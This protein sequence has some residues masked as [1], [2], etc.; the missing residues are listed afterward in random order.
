VVRTAPIGIGVSVA[1]GAGSALVAHNLIA[2]ASTGAV[3]GMEGAK[4]VTGDLAR[5][6]QNRY[7]QI[8]VSG[9]RVR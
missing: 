1:P 5:E 2:G 6:E 8:T 3:I 4:T 9:N 7:A